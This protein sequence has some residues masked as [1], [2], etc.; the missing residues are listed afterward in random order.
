[1][2]I[3][4]HGSI[5]HP[6][7]KRRGYQSPGYFPCGSDRIPSCGLWS[8]IAIDFADYS[9]AVFPA[10]PSELERLQD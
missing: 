9:V 4:L 8:A 5:F 10:Q 2:Q 7:L 1:M 6:A 3:N